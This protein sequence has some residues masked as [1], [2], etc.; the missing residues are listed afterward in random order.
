MLA[1]GFRVRA[2]PGAHRAAGTYGEVLLGH[3]AFRADALR[4][5]AMRRNR[6]RA[7]YGSRHFGEAEVKRDLAHARR[8]H[9]AVR[10]DLAS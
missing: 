8:I 9:E 1:E 10:A 5:D 2:V 3:G 7:E 4:F 6:S